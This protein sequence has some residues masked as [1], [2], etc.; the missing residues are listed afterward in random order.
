MK[1]LSPE[2]LKQY[3]K[4]IK[5]LNLEFNLEQISKNE[6]KIEFDFGVSSVFSS[7][8]EGNSM[9]LNSFF[10]FD[11]NAKITKEKQEI[12]ELIQAYNFAKGHPLNYD[13]LLQAHQIL[14]QSFLDEFQQG[15]IRTNP[16]GVFGSSGLIYL[17]LEP[18][19]VELELKELMAEVEVLILTKLSTQE[20]FYYASFL[21][22]RIAHIHSF[23]DGN[24]RIARLVEK[25]FLGIKLGELGWK[26]KSEQY[27]KENQ[28]L[29]YQNINLG[30]NF[31]ELDYSQSTPFLIM[32]AS[33]IFV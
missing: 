13:N 14:S 15:T 31:W 28:Q 18:D 12:D 27:Y 17:A 16:V 23:A 11:V 3:L 26:I 21:H 33:S 7:N 24:G 5:T 9:D 32:L 6:S 30:D 22:L 1:Q 20:I 8:I 29:Y 10:N 2:Y 4:E 19:K 25:W